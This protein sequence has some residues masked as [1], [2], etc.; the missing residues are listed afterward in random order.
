MTSTILTSI[1]SFLVA[2]G[3]LVAVHEY[4]H[5]W[6]AR[7]LGFKVLRFSIGFGR[8]LFRRV[9]SH[10][11]RTEFVIAALPLG[12]YVKMLDE[13]EGPVSP[14]DRER[15]FQSRSPAARI[16]VLLA[17]PGANFL[18]AIVAFW[19]VFLM[20]VPGLKPEVGQVALDSAAAR[21]GLL[22]GD[23]IVEVADTTV[24][25]REQAILGLLNGILDYEEL[26]VGVVGDDGRQRSLVLSVPASDRRAL[27]EPGALLEGLG[28][29][30]W[31]P[32]IPARVGTVVEGGPAYLA[33]L[34]PG[35]LIVALDGRP[36]DDFFA[37]AD[38]LRARPGE[39]VSLSVDRQGR[40]LELD[41]VADSVEEGGRVIGRI[42]MT[43]EGLAEYPPD[44]RVEERHGPLGAVRPA[45]QETWDKTVL[46]LKFLTRMITGEVSSRN[47][48]GPVNI[49]QYAGLSASGGL[50]YFLGFLALVSISLAVLN[51]LPL[52]ILDGGQVVY[53]VAELVKGSP[54]SEAAQAIGQRIGVMVLVLLMG[55]AFYNDLS[56]L[57]G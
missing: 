22:P 49:A 42:G 8:P 7:R 4:G 2:I 39:A 43:A 44:M 33:G 13:Q 12:G 30:F 18:F 6:A 29:Q 3:I 45:L 26:P 54:V 1:V 51:L 19:L 14:E 25:T 31:Q 17:G 34:L 48:S 36:V 47:L 52:P 56:R 32:R 10:P 46:T 37:L 40:S 5:F 35:D 21:A 55:Y 27:T 9:G 20:G 16:G 53:Q 50:D 11:D 38:L 57:A 23:V 41:M 28:L 15:S 24:Q